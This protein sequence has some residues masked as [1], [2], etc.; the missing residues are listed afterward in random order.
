MSQYPLLF[1]DSIEKKMK[2][3]Q[4]TKTQQKTLNSPIRHVVLKHLL[5]KVDAA[6]VLIRPAVKQRYCNIYFFV[7]LFSTKEDVVNVTI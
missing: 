4:Q 2:S 5:V 6:P 3:S 1:V 7:S